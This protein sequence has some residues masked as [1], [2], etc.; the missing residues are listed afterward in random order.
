MFL[1]DPVLG[2]FSALGALGH[3]PF[4]GVAISGFVRSSWPMLAAVFGLAATANDDVPS[5]DAAAR[6]KA[7]LK[8]FGITRCD[9][10]RSSRSRRR[11]NLDGGRRPLGGLLRGRLAAGE[12][13]VVN[14]ATGYFGSSAVL[15]GLALGAERVV[16]AG[17]SADVLDQVRAAGGPRIRTVVLTGEA[18]ADAEPLID[19]AGVEPT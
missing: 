5:E 13:L 12:T 14:G 10:R 16:A 6:P 15:L 1:E 3:R 8:S 17:R 11:A 19:A 7:L 2:D 9:V 18:G 4:H